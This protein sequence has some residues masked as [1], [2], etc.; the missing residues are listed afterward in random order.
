VKI[1]S[2]SYAPS[3]DINTMLARTGP[4]IVQLLS[5]GVPRSRA[6]IM[7]ALAATLP[8]DDIRRSLMRL[9]VTGG[10]RQLAGKYTLPDGRAA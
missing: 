4:A 5:D 8:R 7:S 3:D 6:A 10:V 1:S 9:A 2:R